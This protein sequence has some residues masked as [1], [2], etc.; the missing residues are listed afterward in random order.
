MCF[1]SK[2]L[3]ENQQGIS[4]PTKP[5][6]VFMRGRFKTNRLHPS[7]NCLEQRAWPPLHMDQPNQPH[8]SSS[9]LSRLVCT[10]LSTSMFAR[11]QGNVGLGFDKEAAEEEERK[12][13]EA[14]W[15]ARE[16][17]REERRARDRERERRRWGRG[18]WEVYPGGGGGARGGG[19]RPSQLTQE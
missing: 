17:E 12:E 18:G 15:A 6:S 7:H 16:K 2:M 14:R 4:P 19:T 1:R 5:V 13:R 9:T 10:D 11:A 3:L 8:Q